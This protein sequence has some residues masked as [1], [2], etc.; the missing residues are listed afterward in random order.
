[1][2]IPSSTSLN[3]ANLEFPTREPAGPLA[4]I[5]GELKV[6]EREMDRGEWVVEGQEGGY[7]YARGMCIVWGMF[8]W[9]FRSCRCSGMIC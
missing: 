7:S 1:M 2:S 5:L 8:W 3:C 4:A 6:E 9:W